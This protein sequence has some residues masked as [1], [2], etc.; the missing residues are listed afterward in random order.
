[1]TTGAEKI[2]KSI[3]SGLLP[4][5]ASKTLNKS[6]NQIEK[7]SQ[8]T[9]EIDQEHGNPFHSSISNHHFELKEG[10]T[11]PWRTKAKTLKKKEQPVS[12]PSWSFSSL[13]ITYEIPNQF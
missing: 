6:T 13:H 12:Y 3:N 11:K 7:K 1:M 8:K 2:P 9:S 4:L 5:K 10:I